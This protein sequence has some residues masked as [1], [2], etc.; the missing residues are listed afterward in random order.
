MSLFSWLF[1]P[2]LPV[3]TP[4]PDFTLTDDTGRVVS[5]SALRGKPVILIFY[6]GDRTPGCTK[7]LCEFRDRWGPVFDNGIE[8]F[9][10]NPGS[11]NSH[12]DFREVYA[13][14]FSLLVDEKQHVAKLYKCSGWIVRRTVY[15]IDA[16]G[17]I[18]FARRGMP[19]PFELLSLVVPEEEEPP[20]D[21]MASPA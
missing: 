1:S 8:V 3:G 17:V 5:L 20:L 19:S 10:V 9:G 14:P 18:R 21:A 6:P 12:C 16:D 13:I 2:P 7:Q 11:A 15:M 4:A